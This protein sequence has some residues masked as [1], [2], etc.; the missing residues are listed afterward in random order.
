VTNLDGSVLYLDQF[1][2]F[3]TSTLDS[4]RYAGVDQVDVWDGSARIWTHA[5]PDVMAGDWSNPRS[6][7]PDRFGIVI[8]NTFLPRDAAGNRFQIF[9]AVGISLHVSFIVGGNICFHS[10]GANFVDSPS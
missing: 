6:T 9:T 5:L 4:G 3:F 8:S 2:V 10:A 7:P 1:Y